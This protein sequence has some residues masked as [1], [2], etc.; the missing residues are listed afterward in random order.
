MIAASPAYEPLRN[1]ISEKRRLTRS[2]SGIKRRRIVLR[3]KDRESCQ[4][5]C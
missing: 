4:I 3:Y 5:R 2:V 1:I